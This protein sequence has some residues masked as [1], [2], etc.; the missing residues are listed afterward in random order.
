MSSYQ[1]PTVGATQLPTSRQ[2]PPHWHPPIR[3]SS[4]SMLETVG[5]TCP[6][7]VPLYSRLNVFCSRAWNFARA[8]RSS[9][10]IA[11]NIFRMSSSVYS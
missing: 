1:R 10:S 11:K 9:F 2:S 7:L 6:T 4:S 5:A 3:R 8:A